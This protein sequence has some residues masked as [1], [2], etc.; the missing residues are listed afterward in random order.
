MIS[1]YGGDFEEVPE[2]SA[3]LEHIPFLAETPPQDA[4]YALTMAGEW[5]QLRERQDLFQQGQ[6]LQKIF[7][8]LEG[9]IHQSRIDEDDDG[10]PVLSL[11]Q[12]VGPGTILGKFDL[13]YRNPH[14][15]RARAV[16]PCRLLAIDSTAVNRLIFQFPD[17]RNQIAPL[18]LISRLRTIP[19]LAETSLTELSFIG[20]VARTVESEAGTTIYQID[21]MLDKVYL[22][23]VGQVQLQWPDGRTVRVGNGS[24]FGFSEQPRSPWDAWQS[25]H[26]ARTASN[27]SL[28]QLSR[29]ELFDIANIH[30]DLIGTKLRKECLDTIRRLTIFR[31]YSAGQVE[32]LLGYMSYYHIAGHHHLLMQQGEI[33]DSLWILMP[34]RRATMLALNEA[35]QEIGKTQIYGPS[36]FSEAA[37]RVQRYL[38]ATIDAE[39]DSQWL[40]LHWT[41]FRVFL[42]EGAE[43]GQE[44]VDKLVMTVD[45]DSLLGRQED[46][47]LYPWLEE[48]ER[49]RLFRRRHIIALVSRLVAPF[50]ATVMMVLFYL[51]LTSWDQL[52]FGLL[53]LISIPLVIGLIAFW[54]WGI[55]DYLND[56]ILVTN[57]RVVRQEKVILVNELRQ[58]SFLRQVQN[59]DVKRSFLGS[60]LGY[61]TIIIQTAGSAVGAISFEFVGDP[62]SIRDAIFSERSHHRAQYQAEGKMVIQ[63]VLEERLGLTLEMPSKVRPDA[64]AM[65]DTEVKQSWWDRLMAYLGPGQAANWVELDRIVWRKHWFVL[66]QHLTFPLLISL[67]CILVAVVTIG[68]LS[69]IPLLSSLA[70][71]A[72]LIVVV[73]LGLAAFGWLS[74][75][76]VDWRNDKY[77]IEGDEVI[78]VE[79]KPLFFAEN[80]RAAR[81]DDI[82]NVQLRMAGP[83][84][85]ILN[86]GNVELQ[87]AA[88]DGDFTFDYVPNPRAVSE[89]IRRRIENV[90]RQEEM[91]RARQRAEELPDWLEIYNRLDA[92]RDKRAIG[93]S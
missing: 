28:I 30:A 46:R 92:D 7:I 37:L 86:F 35:G 2:A 57:M 87:T 71:P 70:T 1:T 56:Y 75:E 91:S 50:L 10:R 53:L 81:L 34:N 42:K 55:A 84:N 44:L 85:F 78:D 14:S 29:R 66:V 13:L 73:P 6:P 64:D 39:P 31:E 69:F 17:L 8:L 67:S 68:S 47:K 18:Q 41:D 58:S 89:E 51:L 11:R 93:G 38:E 19:F 25:G 74:W 65:F 5:V 72:M 26:S 63:N 24:A 88:A 21:E 59:V 12:T 27:V 16:E 76:Y 79:K 4:A 15:V 48:G 32:N 36:Y 20:D 80:R 3:I 62:E 40:R 54:L 90:N 49:L 43:D 9:S 22:V 82:E 33:G 77:I 61:G 45:V 23:S 83:L 52:S 60:L